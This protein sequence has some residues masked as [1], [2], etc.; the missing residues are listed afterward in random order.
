MYF[1]IFMFFNLFSVSLFGQFEFFFLNI[2]TCF[3]CKF[4]GD[5][6]WPDNVRLFQ[7]YEGENSISLGL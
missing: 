2:W 5:T 7:P 4:A 3:E 1:V 6:T